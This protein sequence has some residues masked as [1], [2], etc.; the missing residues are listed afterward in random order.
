M[1]GAVFAARNGDA[2]FAANPERVESTLRGSIGNRA[3]ARKSDRL[4]PVTDS[5]AARQV[6]RITTMTKV[7]ERE[8]PR[9]N[10]FTSVS[11]NLALSTSELSANIPRF[12]PQ[13]ALFNMDE[14]TVASEAGPYAAP[15][16]AVSFVTRDL[17]RVMP[18]I[19]VAALEPIE[20]V[21][22][23]VHDSA[24]WTGPAPPQI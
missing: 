12:N 3:I 11:S 6:I 9:V 2:N 20:D 8:V 1:E 4:P 24:N 13:R 10:P 5:N 15:D 21:L 7:G 23:K 19:R 17:A 22:A 18:R 16:P 14:D